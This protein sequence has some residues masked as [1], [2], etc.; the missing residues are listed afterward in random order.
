[1]A[2]LLTAE[3]PAGH[4]EAWHRTHISSPRHGSVGSIRQ[5]PVGL[6]NGPT[7]LRA[8]SLLN[9]PVPAYRI[10]F[11]RRFWSPVDILKPPAVVSHAVSSGHTKASNDRVG[12][13]F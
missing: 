13:C 4:G 10:Y 1:M 6:E 7:F 2:E 9:M 12:G 11:K 5:L 3:F 8:V